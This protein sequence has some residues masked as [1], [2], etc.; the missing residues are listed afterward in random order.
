MW[1]FYEMNATTPY[2][3]ITAR[4]A[5]HVAIVLDPVLGAA[6]EDAGAAPG[7]HAWYDVSSDKTIL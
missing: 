6:V 5:L 4:V 3:R 7:E 1:L 2:W